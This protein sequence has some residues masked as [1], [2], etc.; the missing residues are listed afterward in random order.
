MYGKLIKISLLIFSIIALAISCSTEN[1]I[2]VKDGYSIALKESPDSLKLIRY[3]E[4]LGDSVLADYVVKKKL[5]GSYLLLVGNYPTIFEAGEAGF[6]LF[7]KLRNYNYRIYYKNRFVKDSYRTI[8]FIGYYQGRQSLYKYDLVKKKSTPYWSRWGRKVLSLSYSEDWNYAFILTAL[9][10]GSKGE[11]PYVRDARLYHYKNQSDD[12]NELFYFGRGMQ[13]YSYWENKDTFKVNFTKPDTLNAQILIQTIYSFDKTGNSVKLSERRFNLTKDGFPTPSSLRTVSI[14]PKVRFHLRCVYE[15]STSFIY[16]KSI[17]ENKEILIKEYK[18]KLFRN[19]WTPDDRYLFLIF[20]PAENNKK[21]ELIVIDNY[22]MRIQQTFH[23]PSFMNLLVR[24][25]LLFFD[26][27]NNGISGVGIYD[28][29]NDEI[30]DRI[31]IPGG[32]GLKFM[33]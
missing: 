7:R 11:F 30:Y 19:V 14:S 26:E 22:A 10:W 32:C 21:S 13:I 18:G 9:S 17:D 31:T 15:D 1:E 28:Y 24:G 27:E 25:N 20:K 5:S 8:L 33:L 2:K 23:G 3:A 6:N 12:L 4:K 29:V 16:L